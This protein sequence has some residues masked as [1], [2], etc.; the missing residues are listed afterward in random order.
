MDLELHQLDRRYEKLRRTSAVKERQL[1]GSLSTLGQ[2]MPVIVVA[3][4]E[5][6][7]FILVDGYKRVRALRRLRQDVVRATHWQLDEAEALL[8]E[9]LMRTSEPDSPIEQ[10]WLLQEL[11]TRFEMSL[12]ELARRFD[13]SASWVSRR[14]ALVG[15]LPESIQQYVRG[16]QVGAHAAMKY[17]VP[18]ARANEAACVALSAALA[19]RR[20]SSRQVGEL[21]AGW[22]SGSRKTRELIVSDPWLYLRAQQE[23]RQAREGDKPVAQQLREE[24]GAMAGIARRAQRKLEAGLWGKLVA[25]DREQ[26][27]RCVAQTK[28]DAQGLFAQF[29]KEQADARPGNADGNSEVA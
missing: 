28:H 6:G 8:L 23:A 7:R 19:S 3:G 26:L 14:L 22:L 4:A 25:P 11:R 29:D 2:L 10:G 1:A 13:K 15:E 21:Y 12:E 17:L 16:G 5:A 24:L 9:R 18:L 27:A 20:A